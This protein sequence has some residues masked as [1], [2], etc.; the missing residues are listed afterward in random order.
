MSWVCILC[1]RKFGK[2]LAC[3][4][5]GAGGGGGGSSGGGGGSSGGGGECLVATNHFTQTFDINT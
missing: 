5:G 4:A 2:E 1:E 3:G